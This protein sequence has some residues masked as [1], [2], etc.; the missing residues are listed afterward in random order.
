MLIGSMLLCGLCGCPTTTRPPPEPLQGIVEFDEQVLSFEVSGSLTVR[1]VDEG[2]T[3]QPGQLL[4]RLDDTLAGLTRAARADEA[5][6]ARAELDLMQAGPRP[7]DIRSLRALLAAAAARRDLALQNAARQRRLSLS[8]TI[9]PA[10]REAAEAEL[11]EAQAHHRDVA[12]QLA[13]ARHGARSEELAAA[14]ARASAAER[15]LRSADTLLARHILHADHQAEVT[16]VHLDP[17]EFAAV[18]AP[19]I[20][21]GDVTHPYV[22]I[23]VPETRIASVSHGATVA[24]RVDGHA[25]TFRG[26]VEHV[27]HAMEFTPK[28][29][30]S[31]RERPNL[32]LRVRVR[33]DAP[34]A[35]LHAG[36]PAFV[37]IEESTP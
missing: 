17:G 30:F 34:A 25:A 22:D 26:V 33:V 32:V 11:S 8:G 15:A 7:E 31:A 5:R 36:A 13:R 3:V 6:A 19:V 27:A 21:L 2:D 23:F 24:V 14:N 4:A 35:D 37:S 20:T 1:A 29:L 28:F 12:A 16:T 10:A 9:P 18:G